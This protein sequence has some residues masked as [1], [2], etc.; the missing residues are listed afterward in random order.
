MCITLGYSYV[1]DSQFRIAMDGYE[2]RMIAAA[3]YVAHGAYSR[4]LA[5]VSDAGVRTSADGL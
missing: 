1:L 3:A 5:F 2:T 4:R